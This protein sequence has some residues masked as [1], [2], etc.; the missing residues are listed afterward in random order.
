MD[1]TQ[2]TSQHV[3]PTRVG[4]ADA[5]RVDARG[6]AARSGAL[7]GNALL[8]LDVWGQSRASERS[9]AAHVPASV[10][11]A[12]LDQVVDFILDPLS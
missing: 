1:L 11:G 2:T 7:S 3:L 8:G 4:G 10:L 6:D 9:L 5:G 12:P